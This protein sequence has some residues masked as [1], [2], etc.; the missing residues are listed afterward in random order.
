MKLLL[1]IAPYRFE[2]LL[3]HHY[4]HL[5]KYEFD[6]MVSM[7]V[8]CE[9][10]QSITQRQYDFCHDLIGRLKVYDRLQNNTTMEL[11]NG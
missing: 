1:S 8:K 2:Q 6:F 7:L 9:Q 4:Q 5:S 3:K 10:Q 11:N